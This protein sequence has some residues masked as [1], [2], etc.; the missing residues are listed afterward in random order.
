[1][2]SRLVSPKKG[3]RP[4]RHEEAR[5]CHPKVI[6]A[7]VPRWVHTVDNPAQ[8]HPIYSYLILLKHLT[9]EGDEP[10]TETFSSCGGEPH[11]KRLLKQK[12]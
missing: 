3:T 6:S 11:D 5:P 8:L 7:R 12:S 1:M 10:A 4:S 2:I 9:S